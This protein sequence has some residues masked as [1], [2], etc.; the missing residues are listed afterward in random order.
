MVCRMEALLGLIIIVNALILLIYYSLKEVVRDREHRNN[1]NKDISR[2]FDVGIWKVKTDVKVSL[3]PKNANRN[4]DQSLS[5]KNEFV[6][7][8]LVV[9]LIDNKKISVNKLLG[10]DIRND[11]HGNGI[12]ESIEPRDGDPLFR[13]LYKGRDEVVTYNRAGLLCCNVDF[14]VGEDIAH[15]ARNN[16]NAKPINADPQKIHEGITQKKSIGF[17]P[18]PIT[19]KHSSLRVQKNLDSLHSRSEIVIN[20]IQGKG[21]Y[22]LWHMTHE[23]NLESI[24]KRGILS[25]DRVRE[26][27]CLRED[28]SLESVQNQRKKIDPHYK[29]PLHSY[30]PLYVN[31]KNPMLYKRK[32]RKFQIIILEISLNALTENIFVYSDGNAASMKTNFYKDEAGIDYI[33]W[34]TLRRGS[35]SGSDE[36]KRRMCTEFL[37]QNF[38]RPENIK[39]IHSCSRPTYRKLIQSGLNSKYSKDK[40][41]W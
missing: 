32:E 30:I 36:L 35:W 28:I 22:S 6:C 17:N 19:R 39:V 9:S 18:R 20:R 10:L 21:V 11:R 8:A 4:M 34:E 31:P 27:G 1:K 37:V 16:A 29:L 25:H 26:L 24:L 41:F 13:I 2:N 38:I 3:T 14:H 5:L 15:L 23:K 12:V 33:D 7:S 40:Y